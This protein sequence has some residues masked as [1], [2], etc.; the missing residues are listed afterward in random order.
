L[1]VEKY[2]L[3]IGWV[4]FAL[5]AVDVA[6]KLFNKI[7][8]KRREKKLKEDKEQR[9]EKRNK[10]FKIIK[11]QLR[12][13][14]QHYTVYKDKQEKDLKTLNKFFSKS[15][16]N[17]KDVLKLAKSDQYFA[18]YVYSWPFPTIKDYAFKT[19]RQYPILLKSLGFIRMGK[20]SSFFM[21]NKTKLKLKKLQNIVEF[22]RFLNKTL[23]D[24]RKEEFTLYLKEAKDHDEKLYSECLSK[25]YKNYLKINYLLFENII[26]PGNIGFVDGEFIGLNS[27]KINQDLAQ[28]ILGGIDLAKINL[29]KNTKLKIKEYFKEQDFD[30]L[31]EEV[32]QKTVE[33]ISTNRD[34]IKS[35]LGLGTILDI[36]TKTLEDIENI[37]CSIGVKK[38]KNVALNLKDDAKNYQEALERLRIQFN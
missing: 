17:E 4:M 8:S 32:D 31:L 16:L 18:L 20:V 9:W 1:R 26:H 35:N 34:K 7:K 14:K 15:L 24:V 21:I 27:K 12:E 3:I 19:K 36:G 22:K 30:I 28:E 2:K 38:Y 5:L 25:G 11:Q 29:D 33:L 37:L 6:L 23:E 10:D 13:Q